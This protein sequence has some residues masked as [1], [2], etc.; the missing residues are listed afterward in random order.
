MEKN[1][2]SP[3]DIAV[4]LDETY[5]DGPWGLELAQVLERLIRAAKYTDAAEINQVKRQVKEY[6]IEL[7]RIRGVA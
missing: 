7:R 3:E 1:R 4:A 2:P 5:G 6:F